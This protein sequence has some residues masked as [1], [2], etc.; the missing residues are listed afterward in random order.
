ML[1][2]M[3]RDIVCVPS[4]YRPEYLY[5]T[6]ESIANAVTGLE[7]H[8]VIAQDR[9]TYDSP[10]LISELPEIEKVVRHFERIFPSLHY[11]ERRPHAYLGNPYNFLELYKDAYGQK[12]VRYV[13]LIEDDVRVAQD[14]F[15]WHE[16]VQTRA[17]YFCTV[18]WH[19]IRN[20]EVQPSTDPTKYVETAV[21]FSS[22]GV[23][24]KRENLAPVVKH[25]VPTYYAD[26]M[27]YLHQAFPKS[28]ISPRQWTEQAGLIMRI[29]LD[30]GGRHV[31]AWP[32]MSR[33]SHIGISG[34]HRRDGHKF[35]GTLATRVCLLREAAKNTDAILSLSS[36]RFD[37]IA[38]LE[39][40]P[41]WKPEDLHV[42]QRF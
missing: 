36:E 40:I 28:P 14:F 34:Y 13:Y 35:S 6:L 41:E 38:A 25:A 1:G 37:D 2:K 21:D 33:C 11:I 39:F 32:S 27:S 7:K 29:L 4:Y 24:W 30:A 9:H 17:N 10:E 22:I 3:A 31:V 18:G 15:L 23:C 12:D 20:R 26:M 5:L 16:A 19:C 42:V 8:V